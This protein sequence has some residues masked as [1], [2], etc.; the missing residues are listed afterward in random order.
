[1][2]VSFLTHSMQEVF[3]GNELTTFVTLTSIEDK[4]AYGL[5]FVLESRLE[6]P[7]TMQNT[8]P[9]NVK[10]NIDGE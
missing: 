4:Y 7:E 2:N 3:C 10:L 9:F 6:L 5:L 8:G 1:M